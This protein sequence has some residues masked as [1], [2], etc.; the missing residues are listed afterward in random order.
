MRSHVLVVTTS[1]AAALTACSGSTGSNVDQT[2]LESSAPVTA[3]STPTSATTPEP[4]PLEVTAPID[5]GANR[6]SVEE[7]KISD[8][9]PSSPNGVPRFGSGFPPPNPDR[10]SFLDARI[11]VLRIRTA[12]LTTDAESYE[13][14]VDAFGRISEFFSEQSFD[15]ARV[16]FIH[17]RDDLIVNLP[18]TSIEYGLDSVSP[19]E[20]M[21]FVMTAAL[22]Q[23]TVPDDFQDG[24]QILGVLPLS[25]T[26]P[27]VAQGIPISQPIGNKTSGFG[28]LMT[29]ANATNWILVAHEIGHSWLFL[30]DLYSFGIQGPYENYLD[31]WDV[32]AAPGGPNP[33]FTSWTRWRVGWIDDE[34]VRC[35]SV[36]SPAQYFVARLASSSSATKALVIPNSEHSATVTEVR[37]G[38]GANE[39]KSVVVIYEVDTSIEHGNGPIRLQ[40]TLRKE[41]D[42]V[43]TKVAR[44][45]LNGLDSSGA[46]ITISSP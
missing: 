46:I 6:L 45:S 38:F 11:W 20:D 17:D 19:Q 13:L 34:Q 25:P 10:A 28:M 32:M 2:G 22:D 23:W 4:D 44:L 14:M 30:E 27:S 40:G 21:S 8:I 39:G 26:R 18:L 9:T 43:I 3:S 1:I 36:G 5:D 16:R 37:D 33:G 29:P 15:R 35:T 42:E 24:D 12:D 31:N 7:C 41:G